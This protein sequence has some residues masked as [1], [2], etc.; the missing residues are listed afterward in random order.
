MLRVWIARALG[1]LADGLQETLPD[2][3][4]QR[5]E[6]P[7]IQEAMRTVHYPGEIEAARSARTRF[8]YEELLAIQLGVLRTRAARRHRMASSASL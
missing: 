8:A 1:Q 4:R 6:F 5:Y 2:S 7:P 3:L